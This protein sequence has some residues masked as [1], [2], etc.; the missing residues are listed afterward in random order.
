VPLPATLEID[1][2]DLT[3]L[4][5]L[6]AL[7]EARHVTMREADTLA[8]EPEQEVLPICQVCGQPTT[9]VQS[10]TSLEED[11]CLLCFQATTKIV[12]RYRRA[13]ERHDREFH[14]QLAQMVRDV[15]AGA[16]EPTFY[17]GLE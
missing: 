1:V 9:E 13:L 2:L 16:T 7:H 3:G 8:P 10:H 11:V 17:R 14:A 4:G 6:D 12:N 5:I 15:R